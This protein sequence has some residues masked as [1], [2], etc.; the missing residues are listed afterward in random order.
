M[1]IVP[2]QS[3]IQPNKFKYSS[4]DLLKT[5]GI[6]WTGKILIVLHI[7]I[8]LIIIIIQMIIVWQ[9]PAN[10]YA[11]GYYIEYTGGGHNQYSKLKLYF[12][13]FF[14]WL[15]ITIILYYKVWTST[16]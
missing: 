2:H 13:I 5:N 1:A 7:Q 6:H 14:I 9:Y 12:H 3:F 16:I 11:H 15:I 10:N 8:I 4:I